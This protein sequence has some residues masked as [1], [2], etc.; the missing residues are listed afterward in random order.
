MSTFRAKI[1]NTRVALHQLSQNLHSV[2]L[3]YEQNKFTFYLPS[4]CVLYS[5]DW[6]PESNCKS[7]L[8]I[9]ILL[10]VTQPCRRRCQLKTAGWTKN[11][12]HQHWNFN[13]IVLPK[14]KKKKRQETFRK[15]DIY[16]NYDAEICLFQWPRGLRRRSTAA[17]LLKLWV[18]IPPEA[19]KF[20]CC[21]CCVLSGR[22][23]CDELITR[24]QESYYRLW[25]VVVCDLET[26]WMR[27]P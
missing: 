5:S 3:N 22:G 11:F 12:L 19:W 18:R 25:C 1:K 8:Q 17:R 10:P 21:M 7:R 6:C 23:L 26:S 16:S 4:L 15:R 14:I 13:L 9:P 2:C 27:R 20:V 24:P